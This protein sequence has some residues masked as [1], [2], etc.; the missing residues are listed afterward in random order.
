M[1]TK[2][3]CIHHQPQSLVWAQRFELA[4]PSAPVMQGKVIPR[5]HGHRIN[6]VQASPAQH[7]AQLCQFPY[8]E[9]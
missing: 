1:A 2:L 3:S 7:H 6:E 5:V 9:E 4:L 8:P